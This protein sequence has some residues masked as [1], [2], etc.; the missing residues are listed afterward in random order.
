MPTLAPPSDY[1]EEPFTYKLEHIPGPAEGWRPSG[2]AFTA[3]GHIY[4]ATLTE[5]RVYRAKLPPVPAPRRFPWQLYA[6]GLNVPTGL[7]AVG[8]RLFV[9]QRPEVT[10]LIDADG[11]G[12]AEMFRTVMGSWSLEDGFHEYAFGLAVDPG[13]RLYCALNNGYFWSYGGPTH[14][15]RH[16][17]AVMRS[18]LDGI[19]EEFGRGCRVPNG[20]CRGPGGEVF[21][22]DNQGDWV[23]VNKIVHCR[24]GVFYG[25]PETEH[26][27]LPPGQVPDGLPAVWIPY[28]VIRSAAALCYDATGGRFGPFAGQMFVGDVGYGQSVNVMR[29]AL[30]QVDGVWQGACF[31]FL[32]D[33][34][35]GPQHGAFGPDGNLY[36]SC[37]ADG[38]VR[39]RFG[40]EVPMEIHH[41]AM[42][43]DASGFVLHFTRP[44]AAG[45]EV[46]PRTIRVRRWY[47]PYG[48]R[49]GSPRVE[50]VDVPVRAARVAADRRSIRVSVP[51]K[52]YKNC[53]VYYFNVGKLRSADGRLVEHPQAWYTVQ[54]VWK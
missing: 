7:N 10:E 43:G 41:V 40:G 13:R 16:R 35:R 39:V 48:I 26:E 5:G 47:Y 15:G 34:P 36:I 31:R 4:A 3:D 2:T 11:D 52:T 1:T 32:D 22:A 53:M 8:N 17:S 37:L 38:L 49:Y 45:A 20:I 28:T 23:Q 42:C 27:F 12:R 14:R 51:I 9:S 21:Y 19:S 33:K 6:T 46:S 50:E 44:I 54:R 18:T 29:V 30:E 25:H 24:K